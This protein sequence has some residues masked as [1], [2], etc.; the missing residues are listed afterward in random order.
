MYGVDKDAYPIINAR[1]YTASQTDAFDEDFV[2]KIIDDL[3]MGGTEVNFINTSYELKRVYQRYM[4]L[5]KKNIEYTTLEDGMKVL[6]HFGTPIVPTAQLAQDECYFLNTN[7]FAFYELGDWKWLED[8]A[9]R[10]LKQHP[11]KP[12]FAA[13]LVKYTELLCH[14][15]NGVGFCKGIS[16]TIAE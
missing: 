15:P 1:T 10:V 2:Q 13:T 14:K 16:T 6:T 5:Y 9:G 12:A 8:E 3:E 7:D 11:S 4:T